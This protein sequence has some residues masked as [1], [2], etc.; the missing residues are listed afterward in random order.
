MTAGERNAFPTTAAGKSASPCGQDT[1]SGSGGIKQDLEQEVAP[2]VDAVPPPNAKFGPRDT[3]LD[4]CYVV[5]K[6]SS[7][8]STGEPEMAFST[9]YCECVIEWLLDLQALAEVCVR[10]RDQRATPKDDPHD[11]STKSCGPPS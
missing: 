8:H 2:V 11:P 3:P 4:D 7:A 9:V 1:A 5:A 10:R 6:E